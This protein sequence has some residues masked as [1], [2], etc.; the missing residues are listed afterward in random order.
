MAGQVCEADLKQAFAAC[1]A[2]NS[3]SVSVAELA[4]VFQGASK[5]L[6]Q[7][8]CEELAQVSPFAFGHGAI[9]TH[10]IFV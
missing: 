1:D 5:D 4:S 3:G 9:I 6:T 7:E 8:Q 10:L 2:D